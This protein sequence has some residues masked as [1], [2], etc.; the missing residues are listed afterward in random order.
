MMRFWVKRSAVKRE[1]SLA[2]FV[3][4]VALR[5]CGYL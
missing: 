5:S 2:L 3:A 1:L 4:W